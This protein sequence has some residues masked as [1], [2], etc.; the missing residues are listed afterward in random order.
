[1]SSTIGIPDSV[2][3]RYVGPDADLVPIK[4]FKED[5]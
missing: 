3:T 4:K 5:H 2:P 1:M